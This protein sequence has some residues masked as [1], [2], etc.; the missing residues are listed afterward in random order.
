[1]A[2]ENNHSRGD[3]DW[4]MTFRNEVERYL[5]WKDAIEKTDE[6]LNKVKI[7]TVTMIP[8]VLFPTWHALGAGLVLAVEGLRQISLYKKYDRQINQL[9][10]PTQNQ[11]VTS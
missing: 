2:V 3:L 4:Q 7:V 6:H 8:L 9:E 10:K 1:M 11:L 5:K